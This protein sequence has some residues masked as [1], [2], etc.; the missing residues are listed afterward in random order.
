LEELDR[1]PWSGHAVLLGNRK[2]E[3]QVVEGVLGYF[4]KGVSKARKGYREF[5]GDGISMGRRKEFSGGGL[6]RSQSLAE[7]GGG[8]EAFDSRVLGGSEFGQDLQQKEELKDKIKGSLPW[9]ELVERVAHFFDLHPDEI[10]RPRKDRFLAQVRGVVCYLAVR[11]L[12]YRGVE[13]GKELR[14]G[15]A[16][17]SI[18]VGRGEAYLKEKPGLKEKITSAIN[19]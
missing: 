16:G 14:L 2:M 13:T 12:G 6:K 3:G 11:E 8:Y 17:V 19:K 1:Y 15:P 18:A 5:I 10:R 9:M 4:G 7:G